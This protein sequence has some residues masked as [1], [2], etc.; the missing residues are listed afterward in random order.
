MRDMAP[1]PGGRCEI[2]KWQTNLLTEREINRIRKAYPESKVIAELAK[3]YL[4]ICTALREAEEIGNEA[5]RQAEAE[6]DALRSENQRLEG[7][8]D[9]ARALLD[10]AWVPER[11][12]EHF[13]ALKARAEAAER[14][15]KRTRHF[16]ETGCVME[17]DDPRDTFDVILSLL[18]ESVS[19]EG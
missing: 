1:Q 2:R 9:E 10:Q 3:Q 8:R 16:I 6:R 7:E 18:D 17:A 5:S 19:G 12:I 4:Q 15:V 11:S 14:K 13:N